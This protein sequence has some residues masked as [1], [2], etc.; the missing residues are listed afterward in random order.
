MSFIDRNSRFLIIADKLIL[1][2]ILL[3]PVVFAL[4]II[5]SIIAAVQFGKKRIFLIGIVSNTVI[6]F[7]LLCFI[8]AFFT[9]FKFLI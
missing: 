3:T 7:V 5:V 4:G 8:K 6:L 2:V 1:V 9:E